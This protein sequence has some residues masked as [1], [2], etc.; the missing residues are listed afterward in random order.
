MNGEYTTIDGKLVCRATAMCSFATTAASVESTDLGKVS[1]DVSDRSPPISARD[2]SCTDSVTFSE[3]ESI[4]TSAATPNEIDD[5]YS[6]N[7]RRA[8]RLSRQAS[9]SSIRERFTPA[10]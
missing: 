5:M 4:A 1:R 3:K 6:I 2:C 7:R 9:A 10:P 8:V